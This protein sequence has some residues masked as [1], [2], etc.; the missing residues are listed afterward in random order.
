MRDD[1]RFDVFGRAFAIRATGESSPRWAAFALGVEGKRGPAGFVV[2]DFI[3]PD[4]FTQYLH[5][6]FH[7]QAI[8]G[9][10]VRLVASPGN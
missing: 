1:Y 5:D 6:L 4:E 10:E 2:P 7:E 8:R 9:G 3:E